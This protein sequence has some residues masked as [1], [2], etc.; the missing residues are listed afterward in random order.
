MSRVDPRTP[1]IIGAGQINDRDY[2]C[3]PIDLM[4]RCVEEALTDTTAAAAVRPTIGDVRVVWGVWP[5]R[6]PG[7]L[8]AERIGTPTA[9]TTMTTSGGNQLYDLVI[10][11]ATRIQSGQ[12]DTTVVC[13]AESLRT[14]RSDRARGTTTDYLTERDD[15]APDE[16]LGN[17]RDM[18]AEVENEIG[19]NVVS[20]FYAM[21]ETALR[22]RLGD[23]LDE[24]RMR[25]AGLWSRASLVAADNPDAWSRTPLDA[26]AIATESES[27]R[28]VAS[29]YPKLMTSNLNVDQGGAVVMCSVAAARAAG[30][31]S[32]RWI[33]PWSG[34]GVADEWHAT[35]RWAFDETPGMRVSGSRTL[36]LAGIGHDDCALI[37]LYSCFPVAVQLAQR[38]LGIDPARDF[39]ITGGL[40]FAAGPLNCYCILPLTRAVRLL[41]D[42][43]TERA[44]LTGNGGVFTNHSALVLSGEPPA[45]GFRTT[46]AQAEVDA[47][48]SRPSPSA[49]VDRATLETYTVTFDRNMQPE[50]AILACLD[51]AGSRHWAES[52]DADTM[53]EL[54]AN[55][56]CGRPVRLAGSTAGLA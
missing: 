54:L 37:D 32:D 45:V 33:F 21:A 29:P 6:D 56:C 18:F 43:P 26:A 10:D 46:D 15:A 22:H 8:V 9:R 35:N 47:L 48:P 51:P 23:D 7:R 31:P 3:E 36:E 34:V 28:P 11:T 50:R 20:R 40:T 1:V 27:N 5:Y 2:G 38:E 17:E 49:P 24:H 16:L 53:A 14:R 39:T 52:T 30:V 42:A 13:G 41:R 19:V 12:I 55:D 4:A 25:I 44:L